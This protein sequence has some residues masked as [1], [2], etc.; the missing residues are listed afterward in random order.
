MLKRIIFFCVLFSAASLSA[1]E[2]NESQVKAAY[3][4]RLPSFMIWQNAGE[5]PTISICVLDEEEEV[6]KNLS[7]LVEKNKKKNALNVIENIAISQIKDCNIL[8]ISQSKEVVLQ[9]ALA[10]A[11][12]HHV[13]TTSDI[14]GFTRRGGILGFVRNNERITMEASIRNA[15]AN[16]VKMGSKLLSLSVVKITD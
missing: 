5:N 7:A 16:D 14:K 13:M 11:A 3:L 1:A 4:Y 9:D 8:F 15:K 6:G 10:K 2:F 12:K